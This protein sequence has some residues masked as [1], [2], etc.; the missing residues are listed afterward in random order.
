MD[1]STTYKGVTFYLYRVDGKYTPAYDNHTSAS[2]LTDRQKKILSGLSHEDGIGSFFST[3]GSLVVVIN[4]RHLDRD[5]IHN[6]V[7][8]A[9]ELAPA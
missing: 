4:S 8:Q 9:I 1:D 2:T 3:S 6:Q 5:V 7:M